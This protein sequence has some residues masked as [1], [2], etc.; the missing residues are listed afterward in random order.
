MRDAIN[1]NFETDKIFHQPSQLRDATAAMMIELTI[2]THTNTL[3]IFHTEICLY[4]SYVMSS[5][6]LVQLSI[7]L[8]ACN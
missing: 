6:R 3:R 4:V 5:T 7:V 1:L 2:V 8:F